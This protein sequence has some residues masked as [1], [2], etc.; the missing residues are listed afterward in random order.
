M[1][2]SDLT[3]EAVRDDVCERVAAHLARYAA[4]LSPLDSP[5]PFVPPSASELRSTTLAHEAHALAVYALTGTDPEAPGPRRAAAY[6]LDRLLAVTSA[7]EASP[8]HH[9]GGVV[10]DVVCGP[11]DREEYWPTTPA[12][13]ACLAAWGRT[14]LVEAPTITAREVAAV[15]NLTN[16]GAC[17][18]LLGRAGI[19]SAGGV[20]VA[21]ARA[22]LAARGVPGVPS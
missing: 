7:L 2:L 21:R 19:A 18:T 1:R 11:V 13:L 16:P 5:R 12:G 4:T 3:P 6:A 14:R 10:T 9:P 17:R 22:W 15:A 8:W 20:P